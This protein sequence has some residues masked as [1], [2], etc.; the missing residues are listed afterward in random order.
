MSIF[1]LNENTRQAHPELFLT[2]WLKLN[3]EMKPRILEL[4]ERLSGVFESHSQ[5]E[6]PSPLNPQDIDMNGISLLDVQTYLAMGISEIEGVLDEEGTRTFRKKMQDDPL[7]NRIEVPPFKVLKSSNGAFT[8]LK[9]HYTSPTEAYPEVLLEAIERHQNEVLVFRL[10]HLLGYSVP[11]TCLAQFEGSIYV[12]YEYFDLAQNYQAG[13]H[14]VNNEKDLW[15]RVWFNLLTEATGETAVQG[16]VDH[17]TNRYYA[18]DF[19]YALAY[20]FQHFNDRSVAEF[21]DGELIDV[22]AQML[23]EK[24]ADHENY[25][26]VIPV[27][28]EGVELARQQFFDSLNTINRESLE[29]IFAD[30]IGTESYKEFLIDKILQRVRVLPVVYERY[31]ELTQDS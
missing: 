25:Y 29:L 28:D 26:G 17:N 21:S 1:T 3:A 15:N 22:L 10:A 2:D 7:D 8:L 5:D 31:L 16:I 6:T 30:F 9:P 24:D 12:A 27:E 20:Y 13:T 18:Q 23:F 4:R 19:E 14:A 11:K